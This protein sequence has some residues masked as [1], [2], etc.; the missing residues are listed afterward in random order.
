MP[1]NCV[2]A[3]DATHML[4][5]SSWE[6]CARNVERLL[7]ALYHYYICLLERI[8]VYS[9]STKKGKTKRLVRRTVTFRWGGGCHRCC[10][11]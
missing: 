9:M 10:Q 8:F 2:I 1:T 5:S 3:T 6:I 7:P 11:E 4:N